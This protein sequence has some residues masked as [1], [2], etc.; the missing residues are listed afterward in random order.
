MR[1]L[2]FVCLLI[3]GLPV[4]S[5]ATEVSLD[6]VIKTLEVPFQQ[7][8]QEAE[9]I[10]DFQAGFTQESRIASINRV[11]YGEGTVRFRF[12][13]AHSGHAPLAKF[14]WDYQQ[15]TIQEIISDGRLM[16]VYLPDNKQVIESDISH[17]DAQQSENPVTF[18]SALGNL[19]R[20]FLIDW[21][22]TQT[23]EEGNF[24]L[25]LKPRK[26]S[27]L[28]QRME[29]VVNKDAVFEWRNQHK[30]GDKFPILS[31]LVTDQQ[32]NQ[33][34]IRFQQIKVNQNL[35]DHLFTFVKPNDVE[36]VTPEQMAF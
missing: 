17:L 2:F 8:T 32:G 21:G 6:D 19:S 35:P 15:P 18:L 33:T 12:V 29:V 4:F 22:V 31:T 34:L 30:T 5:A 1:R 27:Q 20:D 16:W 28:I 26:E 11:Q 7:H 36:L 9:K 24:L 13:S 10:I 23:D 25:S 14:R 3:I